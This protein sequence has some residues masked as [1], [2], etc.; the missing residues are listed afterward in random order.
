MQ[1]ASRPVAAVIEGGAVTV[2]LGSSIARSGIRTG[3]FNSILIS[4]FV[5]V[6]M[7]NCVASEPVP[8][9]VGIA[10]VGGVGTEMVFP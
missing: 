1:R 2:N 4:L 7:V 9:V 10:T 5:L 3:P 6:I 8:L